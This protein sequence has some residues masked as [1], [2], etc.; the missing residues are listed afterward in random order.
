MID[1]R[2]KWCKRL[3]LK[4]VLQGQHLVALDISD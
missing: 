1:L 3:E 2:I 4:A